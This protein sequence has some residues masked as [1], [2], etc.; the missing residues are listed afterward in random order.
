MYEVEA[1]DSQER[2]NM[3]NIPYVVIF[4]NNMLL[5]DSIIMRS[6][7]IRGIIIYLYDD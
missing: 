3:A 7:I 1:I 4:S 5:N 2:R 6:F